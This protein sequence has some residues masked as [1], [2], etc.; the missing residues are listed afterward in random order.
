MHE[1]YLTNSTAYI[2]L[3]RLLFEAFTQVASKYES[4]ANLIAPFYKTT[5]DNG[6]PFADADSIFSAR[7]IIRQKVFR[8]II[9]E[10]ADK[11]SAIYKNTEHGEETVLFGGIANLPELIA[12]LKEW[13]RAADT[14]LDPKNGARPIRT[15]T[16]KP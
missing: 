2:A 9:E 7:D 6:Q 5:Y 3:E 10:D 14:I 13:T 1:D 8:V 16:N 4:H 12:A 11:V 15:V